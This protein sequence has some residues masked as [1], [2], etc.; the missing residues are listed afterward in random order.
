MWDTGVQEGLVGEQQMKQWSK[1][2]AEYGLQ[3]E[4]SQERPEPASSIGGATQPIGVVRVPVGLARCNGVFRFTVVEQD[5]PPL[6]PVGVMGTLQAGLDLDDNGD[7]VIFRKFGGESPLRTLQSGHTAIRADQFDPDGWQLPEITE[8][9]QDNDQG[10][11]TNYMSAIAHLHQRPRCMDNIHQQETMTQHPH[12]VAD[13]GRRQHLTATDPRDLIRQ[14]FPLHHLGRR[15]VNKC[16]VLF[17]TMGGIYGRALSMLPVPGRLNGMEHC[18]RSN[19]GNAS[20][21]TWC[22]CD[23][24]HSSIPCLGNL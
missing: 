6:L 4:W 23:A 15:V 18:G 11:G 1:L 22:T 21:T 16:T 19:S 12:P 20:H 5:V 10:C 13:H 8:L 7:K 9:C 14:S 2:N 17:K 24:L 3:V